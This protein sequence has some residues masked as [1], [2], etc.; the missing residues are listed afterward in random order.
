MLTLFGLPKGNVKDVVNGTIAIIGARVTSTKITKKAGIDKAPIVIRKLSNLYSGVIRRGQS[1]IILHEKDIIDLGDFTSN[2]L[3][4]VIAKVLSL[5]GKVLLIGGDHAS[6]FYALEK[7]NVPEIL[8]LDAHLDVGQK[9][10]LNHSNALRALIE[11]KKNINAI[12][13]GFRGYSSFANELIEAGKL[14]IKVLDLDNHNDF[15]RLL[16]KSYAI[17]LDVDFFSAEFFSSTVFPEV[18]GM[19]PSEF[20]DIIRRLEL[21][22]NYFDVVEYSP[23]LDVTK[24]DG[25]ILVQM[26]AEVLASL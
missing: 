26:I 25:K 12:V 11:R 24:K 13:Y 5:G 10:K 8:W 23:K 21:K 6:T 19:N 18:R 9:E 2:E 17:S 7:V 16:N 20:I 1:Y 3:P 15:E 22:A 14:G 4:D